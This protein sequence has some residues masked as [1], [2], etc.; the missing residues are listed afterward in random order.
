MVVNKASMAQHTSS[1]SVDVLE[2]KPTTK[3]GKGHTTKIKAEV[4]TEP[5]AVVSE[6]I[7][8]KLKRG[9]AR[10]VHLSS[11]VLKNGIWHMKFLP[12]LMYWVGNSNYG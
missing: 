8:A 12:C 2:Q 9:K 4:K 11:G 6:N 3:Q 5:E 7:H 10:N 1:M